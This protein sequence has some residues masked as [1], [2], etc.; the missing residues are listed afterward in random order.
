MTKID[1][2]RSET[3]HRKITKKIKNGKKRKTGK[4]FFEYKKF[5]HKANKGGKDKER[6]IDPSRRFSEYSVQGIKQDGNKKDSCKYSNK[7]DAPKIFFSFHEKAL[8]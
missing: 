7:L 5:K 8:G 1:K 3:S 2:K 6:D 4:L